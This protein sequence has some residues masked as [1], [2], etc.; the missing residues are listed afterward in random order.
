MKL[1]LLGYGTVGRGVVEV[2]RNNQS[3]INQNAGDE[4]EVKYILDI[5]DIDEED[6]KGLMVKDFEVILQDEEVDIVAEAMG[7]IEPAYT[8]A[9][10]SLLKGKSFVTSNKELVALHGAELIEIAHDHDVNFLFEASVGGGIPIIRPLNQSL[11][12]DEIYEITGILNGTTNFILTKMKNEGSSFDD[13]LKEAQELGYAERNPEAD[14]EGHDACRKIAILSSLAFGE[15]VS[16]Q[17]IPTEGITKVSK[18]DMQYA[19]KLGYVIKLLATCKK[20]DNDIFARVAPMMIKDNHPLAMVNDVFNA[21][22]VKGNAIGDVMFYGKGAGKLP[23]A[24][25]VVA[26]I[27]DAVKHKGTHIISRWGR[28]KI[29]LKDKQKVKTRYFVRMQKDDLIINTL[30]KEMFNNIEV[31]DALSN[32]YAFI[33]AEETEKYFD[34]QFEKLRK[35]AKVLSTIRIEK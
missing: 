2:I 34:E 20:Q 19:S 11:T 9:K 22:F 7:G 13:V 4:I 12:A 15:H 21:I 27:V 24:S 28:E 35:N 33:T 3:R 8:F 31:V 6:V 29:E 32:E 25:A 16:Y 10:A 14:V 23:T 1:A 26:D 30:L 5:R 17:D 18:E